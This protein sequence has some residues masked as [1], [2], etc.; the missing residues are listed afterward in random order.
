V[1]PRSDIVNIERPQQSETIRAG[2]PT[3]TIQAITA[4][5]AWTRRSDG[6][7]VSYAEGDAWVNGQQIETIDPQK[8]IRAG[9]RW[10]CM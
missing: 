4:G 9:G 3:C 7:F 6:S 2:A 10:I 8:G 5:R 1:A